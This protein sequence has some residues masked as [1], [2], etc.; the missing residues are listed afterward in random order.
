MSTYLVAVGVCPQRLPPDLVERVT[1]SLRENYPGV[2][3]RFQGAWIISAEETADHIRDTLQATVGDIPYLLV[4]KAG[5]DAAWAGFNQIDSDWL[6][7]AF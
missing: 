7:R 4:V 1:A 3:S 2:F 6:H 5:H